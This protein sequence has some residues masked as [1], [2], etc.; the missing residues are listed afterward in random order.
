VFAMALTTYVNRIAPPR[1][2]TPT[3]SMGVAMNH[4]AAVVMPFAG[5]LAW[6]YVGYELTFLIGAAAAAVSVLVALRIPR[7]RAPG[8]EP[9]QGE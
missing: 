6:R 4:V 2:H 5:G 1:E 8:A 3:L 9:D 7:R